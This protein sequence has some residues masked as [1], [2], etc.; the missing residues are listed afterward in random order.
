MRAVAEAA[1]G[2]VIRWEVAAANEAA[3]RFY[4]RIGAGLI[5]KVI[6]RWQ[7]GAT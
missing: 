3:Q 4:R 2:R 5:P 6:C 1:E 7:V